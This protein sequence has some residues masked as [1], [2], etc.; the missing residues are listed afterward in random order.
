[1]T[2]PDKARKRGTSLSRITDTKT[3]RRL[4]SRLSVAGMPF[5]WWIFVGHVDH[6][7]YGKFRH[8][9]RVLCAHRVA[10]A[11]FNGPIPEDMTVHHVAQRDDGGN[12][13]PPNKLDCNPEHLTLMP[14]EENIK[15]RN[16]RHRAEEPWSS[17][18]RPCP[19]CP[20]LAVCAERLPLSWR[21]GL[22]ETEINYV[23]TACH[24]PHRI[25]A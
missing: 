19:V 22:D 7:G 20:G 10:Y 17:S 5:G 11:V 2:F 12:L 4:T 1:M 25:F 16:D 14:L 6:T 23:C 24:T 21:I 13:I 18:V 8:G 15:E 3:I 9:D